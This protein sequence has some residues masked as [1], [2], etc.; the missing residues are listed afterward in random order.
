MIATFL[1]TMKISRI[2]VVVL[3]MTGSIAV[4]S[5]LVLRNAESLQRDTCKKSIEHSF[6]TRLRQDEISQQL[7]AEWTKISDSDADQL[8]EF[9]RRQVYPEC[10]DNGHYVHGLDE[11]GRRLTVAVRAGGSGAELEVSLITNSQ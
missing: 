4:I 5:F 3:L 2:V 11:E 10:R 1:N 6:A 9:A 8:F 7:N